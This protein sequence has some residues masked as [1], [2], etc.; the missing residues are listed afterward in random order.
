MRTSLLTIALLLAT[1]LRAD[2][3]GTVVTSAGSPISGASVKLYASTTQL[4]GLKR[5]LD[6]APIEPLATVRSD[7]RGNF[8]IVRSAEA[9]LWMIVSADGHAPAAIATTGNEDIGAVALRTAILKRGSVTAGGKP[10]AGAKVLAYPTSSPIPITAIT[11]D[12]GAYSLPDPAVWLPEVVVVS[13]PSFA[14]ARLSPANDHPAPMAVRLTTGQTLRGRVVGADGKTPQKAT[15]V[16][17]GLVMGESGDDGIYAITRVHEDWGTLVATAA[18]SVARAGR[19]ATATLRLAKSMTLTGTVLDAATRVP[20]DGATVQL[21]R[22]SSNDAP[23]ATA[24]TD[25]RGA[26]RMKG[27]LPGTYL[28][29]TACSGRST[30]TMPMTLTP[31]TGPRTV[32]LSREIRLTGRVTDDARNP[33]S[34]A[35]IRVSRSGQPFGINESSPLVS[36]PDGRYMVRF[37]MMGENADYEVRASRNGYATSSDLLQRLTAGDMKTLAIVLTRGVMLR[38][39]VLGPDG[40]P[41]PGVTVATLELRNARMLLSAPPDPGDLPATDAEGMFSVPVRP[42]SY[43]VYFRLPGYA[44]SLLRDLKVDAE[45]QPIEVTLTPAVSIS[46]RV[47]SSTGD[48]MSGL[49]VA[50]YPQ[51]FTITTTTS[52][53]GA[54]T[55]SGLPPESLNI[56]ISDVAGQ[57]H[58]MRQL[59]AP[60]ENVL[61]ELT[62][63][64]R[65]AGRV[66]RKGGGAVTDFSIL[67]AEPEGSYGMP[68][69]PVEV[70]DADGR[71]VMEKVPVKPAQIIVTAPG[72]AKSSVPLQL[73]KGKDL[74]NVEITLERAARVYGRITSASGAPLD[75]VR[76][77][78]ER[79]NPGDYSMS[80]Y[81]ST[82]PNG[83]YTLDGVTLGEITISFRRPGYQPLRKTLTVDGTDQRLDAQLQTGLEIEGRVVDSSANPISAVELNAA[84]NAPDGS[85]SRTTSDAAGRFKFDGLGPGMYTVRATKRGYL[86]LL[87]KDVDVAKTPQL[88]LTMSSGATINGRITGLDPSRFAMVTVIA[89]AD[90]AN[91]MVGA[92][93]AGT[94]RMEGAPTGKIRVR[95]QVRGN[96]N[97]SSESIELETAAGGTYKADLEFLDHNTIRGHVTRRG[98]PLRSGR[99]TFITKTPPMIASSTAVADDGAYE[100]KGVRDGDKTVLIEDYSDTFQLSTTVSIS[101]SRTMD[102]DLNPASATGRVTNEG[103]GEPVQG[104]EILLDTTDDSIMDWMKPRTT[105]GSDGRFIISSIAPAAYQVRVSHEG[106]APRT[107]ERSFADGARVDLQIAMTP[108]TGMSVRVTDARN[109]R[110]IRAGLVVFDASGKTIWSDQLS[111]KPDGGALVPLEAGTFRAA[112]YSNGFGTTYVRLASP[113]SQEIALRPG[114]RLEVRN[115]AATAVRAKLIA[116]DGSDYDAYP[117]DTATDFDIAPGTSWIPDLAAGRYT[118]VLT[119]NGR[120]TGTMTFEIREGE[121]AK[122]EL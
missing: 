78:Q 38:G 104:A 30:S 82:D 58:E 51:G 62:P 42:A 17:D 6:D 71:F 101:G 45:T 70:H 37:P 119:G 90:G 103:T 8:K 121:T 64:V 12:D 63:T 97:R 56:D 81:T 88:E 2:L 116:A 55:L 69:P 67:T 11:G 77:G 75:H 114:G 57:I 83:D 50:T 102:F 14:I 7:A 107:F 22:E 113:G 53:S 47:V 39:K 112:V 20:L 79:A 72:F 21:L 80:D 85:A 61:I 44:P 32:Y 43:T 4:D 66:I 89:T 120:A 46:G 54:F 16:V 26:F 28:I 35:K 108:T 73:E 115:S 9:N 106:F 65:V 84:P 33:V 109:G 29:V 23:V 24:L 93:P 95:A 52:E 117:Y 96:D 19:G 31:S 3:I 111:P 76:I 122:L 40:K 92:E 15:L 74:D 98:N 36:A 48:A 25:A 5:S 99:I 110:T 105:S 10:V 91:V 68:S 94:F 34:G 60:A 118:L 59:K 18:E 13:H 49:I 27:L 86:D 87:R 41:L 1:S 100:V